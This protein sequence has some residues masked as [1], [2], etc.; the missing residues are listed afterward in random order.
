MV[1]SNL[2]CD[3]F[4]FIG[5]E[6]PFSPHIHQCQAL[7]SEHS[8]YQHVME[9]IQNGEPFVPRVTMKT[10]P[11]GNQ[12]FQ[13]KRVCLSFQS[14]DPSG[15]G[16]F[17]S[18]TFLYSSRKKRLECF[19]FPYDPWLPG[20]PAFFNDESHALPAMKVLRYIPRRRL[21]FQTVSLSD[22][23]KPVIG[24]CL[25]TSEVKDAYEKL[26]QVSDAVEQASVSFSVAAPCGVREAQQVFFQEAKAGKVLSSQI[27]ATS[28]HP[29]LNALG[30]LHQELH[31]LK[32]LRIPT[33]NAEQFIR[34]LQMSIDWIAFFLPEQKQFF[35][36]ILSLLHKQVPIAGTKDFSFC[37]GDFNS[38]QILLE[39]KQ[40]AVVDFDGCLR[41][42]SYLEIAMLLASLQYHIPFFQNRTTPGADS[43]QDSLEQASESYIRG[44]E[45]QGGRSLNRKKLLWYQICAEILYM[46]RTLRR[47]LFHPMTYE[48]SLKLL[49]K[50]S[51][52]L[53]Q[54]NQSG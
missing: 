27:N 41:G 29:L 13:L 47:N 20:A 18:I 21:T 1:I 51:T 9:G 6:H 16:R 22:H 12:K 3:L 35:R 8:R 30:S 42:D 7:L 36:H 23:G 44:Y 54:N 32:V 33:W 31:Q 53:Q 5:S 39:Q 46:T 40:W 24:K 2:T 17:Q 43:R 52:G 34:D 37:H 25:Q 50:L 19:E 10:I 15:S 45:E 48:Q 26:V 14:Q 49:Q 38:N 28:V 4:P 11:V